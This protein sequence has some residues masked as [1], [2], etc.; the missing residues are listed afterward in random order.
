[1]RGRIILQQAPGLER[2]QIRPH[3]RDLFQ[4]LVEHTFV[5]VCVHRLPRRNKLNMDHAALIKNRNQH[6]LDTQFLPPQFLWSQRPL[7]CPFHTLSFSS[8]VV[9]ETPRFIPITIVVKNVGSRRCAAR[10]S[11]HE[12][13]RS[14]CFLLRR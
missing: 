4:Q 3:V 13:T 7:A 12:A 8:R 9:C 14:V 5:G 6:R 1:M 10:R 2:V 11:S